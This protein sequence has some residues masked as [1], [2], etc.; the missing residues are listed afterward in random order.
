MFMRNRF[1][2]ALKLRGKTLSD[3]AEFLQL[4]RS[5][6]YKKINQKSDFSREEVQILKEN[7]NLSTDEMM[8]IFYA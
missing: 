5:T 6:V 7:L 4:N 2:A 8:E 1:E 3:V